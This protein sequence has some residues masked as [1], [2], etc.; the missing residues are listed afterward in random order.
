[1]TDEYTPLDR[2][3][4]A[5]A[6]GAIALVKNLRPKLSDKQVEDLAVMVMGF[7]MTSDA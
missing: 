2:Q 1:M 3:I 4:T 6:Q 5:A 7:V